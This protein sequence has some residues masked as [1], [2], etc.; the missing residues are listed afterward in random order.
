MKSEKYS[1]YLVNT[2]KSPKKLPQFNQV[3]TVTEKNMFVIK[4]LQ[5][6]NF[7]FDLPEDVDRN[8]K[9]EI[10]FII[11]TNES[12][13]ENKKKTILNNYCQ[14]ISMEKIFVNT[15]NSKTNKPHKFALNLSQRLDLIKKLE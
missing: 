15:A 6:F 3:I 10:E 11:K 13:A 4:E 5:N 8:L 14:N 12:L 7:N 1:I 9:H 2:M